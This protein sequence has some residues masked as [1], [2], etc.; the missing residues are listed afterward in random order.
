MHVYYWS[1]IKL[2]SENL[3]SGVVDGPSHDMPSA[4][5]GLQCDDGK[6]M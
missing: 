1:I 3:S 6:G 5:G 4:A 2:T